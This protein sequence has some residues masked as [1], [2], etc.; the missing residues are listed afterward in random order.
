[1]AG[2][3]PRSL[4]QFCLPAKQESPTHSSLQ[5]SAGPGAD[6]PGR[7]MPQRQPDF[8]WQHGH[9]NSCSHSLS[10]PQP[11]TRSGMNTTRKGQ[12]PGLSMSSAPTQVCGSS[13][14][15]QASL[16][17][18]I[19][20]FG[21][22]HALKENRDWSSLTHKATLTTGDHGALLKVWQQPQSR[23]EVPS[24]TPHRL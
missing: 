3:P 13:V 19:P 12:N 21:A 5:F 17:S 22:G 15:A 11:H 4:P 6:H 16:A 2:W 10:T 8:W 23:G 14:N 24:H 20:S 7:K 18:A 1:M 9:L